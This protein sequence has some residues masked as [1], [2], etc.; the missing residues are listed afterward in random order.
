[1]PG[2]AQEAETFFTD[3]TEEAFLEG[4][5]T[6][7]W[8]RSTSFGDYN[9][10]GW[11]DLLISDNERFRIALLRNEENGRFT[12]VST[13]IHVD[14]PRTLGGGGTI[15]GDYDND[16]DLDLFV[17]VGTPWSSGQDVLLRNDRGVFRD[18][19]LEA[20]L[21]DSLQTDNAIWLDYDRDGFL[22]LYVGNWDSTAGNKLHRNNGDG[23][24]ADV[25]KKAG[26]DIQ[27]APY[28][29]GSN[30]GMAAGDFNDDGW[31][32]L[33]VGVFETPNW[34][35]L[36]DGQ[37]GFEDAITR[38]IGDPGQA[39]GVTVGDIN[40]DG[41]LDIFQAA[42]GSLD[43][44]Y[45]SLLLLNQGE[46]Q[47]IDATVGLGLSGNLLAANILGA[48]LADIDN[49]GDLDLMTETPHLLY[50]NT[51][52]GTFVDR[53]SQ[54]GMPER[55]WGGCIS[56][57]DYDRDG[58]LDI[59][60]SRYL[61]HNNG[62]DN[63]WLR[64]E[65]VG[66]ESNR[67]G[68]GARLIATSGDL[69]QMREILGGLGYYQD[70]LVA[71]FGL[72]QHTQVEQLEIRWPSGQKDVL[73]DVPA[74]Q[75]IRVFEG[76]DGYHAVEPTVWDG[77][78]TLVVG[79][80]A[81]LQT[82]VRPSL[83]ESDAEIIGVTADLS[84]LGGPSS[85][86]LKDVGGGTYQLETTLAVDD[87]GGWR[88][89]SFMIDQDTFLGVHWANF[90]GRVPVLPVADLA[91][92]DDGPRAGW[93]IRTYGTSDSDPYATTVVHSGSSAHA[94]SFQRFGNVTYAFEGVGAVDLLGY[95]YLSFW[96][97]PGDADIQWLTVDV[98]GRREGKRLIVGLIRDMELT[99]R[100]HR[101]I[102]VLIPLD[103]LVATKQSLEYLRFSGKATGTFYIDDMKLEVVGG[104]IT[105]VEESEE[106]IVPSVYAL[107]QNHPNPFNPQTTI[108][109]DVAKTSTVRLHIYAITGQRIRT[110]MDGEQSAGSYLLMWDGRDDT[111]QDVASGVYLCRM[112]AGDYRAV[113][114]MILVR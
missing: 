48:G 34:L 87:P 31:P 96:I 83:F 3:V 104:S 108:T 68:I 109:Y 105:A 57:G 27:F 93:A 5:F 40:N 28:S 72:G 70:E 7:R 113:R 62:N 107:P 26:L 47:F 24:F 97:Y 17:S 99:L 46:G 53:T 20:G 54:S 103:D 10:D 114:K 106:M 82:K 80:T 38:E 75:K 84:Q 110:L 58:F 78:D 44:S 32:D 65:L 111:G 39:Y 73:H 81:S 43:E 45:R 66:T 89:V 13:A 55:G 69:R 60:H 74:D 90:I 25:T 21:T 98:G 9:N 33:Y 30:G 41:H 11:P 95:T 16:G 94:V 56:F 92:Y 88:T 85:A 86:P 49:D 6:D 67:T 37:G 91:I 112:I 8:A 1:V 14:S 29:P 35:F 36:N 22:D 15:F 23:T 42:G 61:Y 76:R 102:G 12:D 63:H 18:V 52:D 2:E 79:T 51:G 77:L 64:V 71:H 100:G 101:W 59:L 4:G 50:I 19:T